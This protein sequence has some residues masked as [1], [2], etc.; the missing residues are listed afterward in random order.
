MDIE[1]AEWDVLK[2][3]PWCSLNVSEVLV[4]VHD[5]KQSYTLGGVLESAI[6][7]LERCG[8]HLFSIEPVCLRCPAPLRQYELGF[9]R[10]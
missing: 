5:F 3:T 6:Y 1:G 9:L 10:I 7:P 8:F 4:E 2:N